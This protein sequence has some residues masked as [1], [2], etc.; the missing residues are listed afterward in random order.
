MIL[1]VKNLTKKF[2]AKGGD[3]T[4]VDNISFEINEGE[5]L[6]F[7]GP[8]GAG[9]TT[10]I[11]ILLGLIT[12]TAGDIFIFEKNLETHR[13]EI[14]QQMNFTSPY[15]SLPYRLT[16]FEN[17][18][19][20]AHLYN[21]PNPKK[22]IEELI[23]LF[24]IRNLRDEPVSHLSAG[25][26]TRVGLAKAL[27]NKP[28]LILL[29]EPTAS[30]DPQ[31]AHEAREILLRVQKEERTTILYTSHN[32]AEIEKLCNRIVFLNH[33]RIIASGTLMEVTNAILREERKEPA[34]EEVFFRA[35]KETKI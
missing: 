8:N 28:R 7:L 27:L 1:Q 29:D 32:M 31:M 30:L 5:I 10:T 19:I 21:V 12:P 11:Y 18:L 20:F 22:R 34:L 6:G 9:K 25:E 4:A 26:N 33:G 14:L 13:Q 23:D 24:G 35:V 16:V 2:S 3:F 17:L 15:V